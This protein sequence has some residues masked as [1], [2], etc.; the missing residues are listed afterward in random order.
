MSNRLQTSSKQ[1]SIIIMLE[2]HHYLGNCAD[3]T[4][5]NVIE[6]SKKSHKATPICG[7]CGH[8]YGFVS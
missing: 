4:M 1:N 3:F 5:H 2:S 8:S 7:I 6:D